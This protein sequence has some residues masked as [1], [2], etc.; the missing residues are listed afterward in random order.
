MNPALIALIASLLAQNVPA[1][2]IV[3]QAETETGENRET[4]LSALRSQ[5]CPA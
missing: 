4:I 5:T 3:L 2:Q 1:S